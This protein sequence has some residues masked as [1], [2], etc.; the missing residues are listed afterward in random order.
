MLAQNNLPKFQKIRFKE[1]DFFV[2]RDDLLDDEI[3]GNK[4]RKLEYFLNANLK[5]FSTLYSYGSSQ[6]NAMSALS[7]FAKKKDL[8]FIYLTK[9][10]SQFLQQNPSA[11]YAIALA[12]GAQIIARSDYKEYFFALKNSQN[13]KTLFIPEGIACKYAEQGFKTQAEQ[14][15]NFMQESSIK[16]D[17]FLPSG[18]GT[19]CAYLAKNLAQCDVFT[20]P[21][22]CDENYLNSQIQS[23]NAQARI[24]ILKPALKCYFGDLRLEFYNIWRELK[25]Q[26]GIE[27]ELIYDPLGWITMLE[28]LKSFKNEILYIHQG[29]LSGLQSQK[30]RYERKFKHITIK[31]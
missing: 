17:I 25:E 18:T 4:A 9:H 11:N 10:L 23:L 26:T 14:I 2:L 7:I 13:P 29:G 6:S 27:F 24:K 15:K 21:C 12:N 5:N 28:N 20:T 30:A 16:F 1:R 31:I 19:A 8:K 22:V 3:N